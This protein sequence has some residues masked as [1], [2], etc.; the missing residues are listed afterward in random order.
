MTFAQLG[1][2]IW[3]N[4][5]TIQAACLLVAGIA[6]LPAVLLKSARFRKWCASQVRELHGQACDCLY[7]SQLDE[8]RHRVEELEMQSHALSAE[9]RDA[10]WTHPV[11]WDANQT[12]STPLPQ[13]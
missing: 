8:L 10:S 3:N 5:G 13:A 1:D 12:P 4:M 7:C 11:P 2:T 6:L 9:L